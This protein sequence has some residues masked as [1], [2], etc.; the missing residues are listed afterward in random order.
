MSK[1]EF[2]FIS[3]SCYLAIDSHAHIDLISKHPPALP[4]RTQATHQVDSANA[5]F[6]QVSDLAHQQ[7]T[8]ESI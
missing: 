6:Q 4:D 8:H 7:A 3:A 1:R 2:V 5:E